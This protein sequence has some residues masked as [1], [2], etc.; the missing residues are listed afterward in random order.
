MG[1]SLFKLR[2]IYVQLNFQKFCWKKF[3]IQDNIKTYFGAHGTFGIF[4]FYIAL[5]L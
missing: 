4:I 3:I 1:H 5:E 2:R